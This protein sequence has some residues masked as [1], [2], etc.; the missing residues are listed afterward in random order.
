MN[1][2][3]ITLL[4]AAVLAVIFVSTG[5]HAGTEVA[6]T[7]KMEDPGYKKRKK[8]PPKFKLVEFT[9]KKHAEDYGISCGDCHHDDKGKP[10]EG[11]KMGDDVQKCSECHN[12]FKKDKKNKKDIMV[13]ENAMHKNCITCHKDFNKKKNPKDKKGM[14]GPA[15]ASCGKCHPKNK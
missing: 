2:R 6:D 7:F 8:G 9:H 15:P 4:L 11:L 3:F 5:L 10:I 14:K 12:K 1:K 13:H